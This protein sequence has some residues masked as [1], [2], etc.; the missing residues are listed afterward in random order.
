MSQGKERIPEY[1][2]DLMTDTLKQLDV[3][4]RVSPCRSSSRVESAED[5]L[6]ERA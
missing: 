1:S 2:L 4:A 3:G 6:R 5:F